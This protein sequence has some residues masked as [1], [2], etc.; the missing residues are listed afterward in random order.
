M[1]IVVQ[2]P[3]ATTWTALRRKKGI[4][5]FNNIHNNTVNDDLKRVFKCENQ[6]QN[7]HI[8][9]TV[10]GAPAK[11]NRF[12]CNYNAVILFLC[13]L[14]YRNVVLRVASGKRNRQPAIRRD[15]YMK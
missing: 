1:H 13:Y 5:H 9:Y 11:D 10:C 7:T 6:N 15:V 2:I 12:A 3:A 8:A 4:V 14:L